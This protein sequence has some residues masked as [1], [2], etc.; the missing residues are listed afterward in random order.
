[1][2]TSNGTGAVAS[3][4][5]A[6]NGTA[7][8]TVI[9][10][11][12]D[13]GSTLTYSI[14]GGADAARFTVDASTGALSFVSAPDYETPTDAGANN[15]YDVTVQVSDGTL[16]DTQ[17]IAVAVADVAEHIQL[18]NGGV[19]FADT[20]VTELSITGGTGNDTIT[21]MAGSIIFMAG[22]ATTQS[23]AGR[24]RYPRWWDRN[25]HGRLFGFVGRR[26]RQSR[27][28]RCPERR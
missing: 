14:V 20:G 12:A 11:D 18:G 13:T 28:R 23:W 27:Q 17:T 16:T 7:V 9:A 3:V 4:N 22:P 5:L 6:E 15:V 2:I 19:T 25:R 1:V 24:R 26:N 8:T 21:G 10:T